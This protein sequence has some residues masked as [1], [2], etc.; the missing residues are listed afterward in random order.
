M[1]I[2]ISRLFHFENKLISFQNLYFSGT[3]NTNHFR[4]A[5]SC[6]YASADCHYIDVRGTSQENIAAEVSD[7]ARRKGL[8]QVPFEMIWH[9]KSR[10][11]RGREGKL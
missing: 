9:I 3:N 6:H 11:V 4:K 2:N 1:N 10:L 5:I 7:I 8:S